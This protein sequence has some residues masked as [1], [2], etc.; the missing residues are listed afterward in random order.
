VIQIRTY[1]TKG[2]ALPIKRDH[3]AGVQFLAAL[4]AFS[5]SANEECEKLALIRRPIIRFHSRQFA[6]NLCEYSRFRTWLIPKILERESDPKI[7]PTKELD[8]CL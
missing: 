5:V 6:T 2:P 3:V 4:R 1:Q 8:H 7:F